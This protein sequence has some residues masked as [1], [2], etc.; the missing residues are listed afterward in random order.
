M[1]H[2]KDKNAANKKAPWN[3]QGFHG[4]A[5]AWCAD[6]GLV[7]ASAGLGRKAL[8]T[9]IVLNVGQKRADE[10]FSVQAQAQSKAPTS[11]EFYNSQEWKTVRYQALKKYGARCQCCGSTPRDG[12][13]MHVDHIKPRSKYPHLALDVNNL[14]I[15]CEPCNMG[16]RAWDETDWREKPPSEREVVWG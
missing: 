7:R 4:R 2:R 13:Q 9:L 14:Q 11:A 10:I 16:K 1:G 5:L 8:W 15:L 3:R 12:V 6:N